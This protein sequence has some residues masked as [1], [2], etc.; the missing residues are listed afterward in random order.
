MQCQQLH[1]SSKQKHLDV[2]NCAQGA[3]QCMPPCAFY[4]FDWDQ[5]VAA[6]TAGTCKPAL[7]ACNASTDCQTYQACAA[8]CTT[9]VACQACGSTPEGKAGRALYEAYWQCVESTC[10]VES[11]L[12]SF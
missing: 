2:V 8:A 7:D 10:L 5:C 3:S 6:E 4:S 12:P 11:W 9:N 1:F